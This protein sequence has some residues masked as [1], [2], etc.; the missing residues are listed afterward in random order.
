MKISVLSSGSSGNSTLIQTPE[1]SILIDAGLSAKK[2][3]ERLNDI[4][5]DAGTV[6]GLLV[7]HDH[8]DHISGA[9]II[10]R[11]LKIP[12]YI[13]KENHLSSKDMFEKCDIRYIGGRFSVGNIEIVPFPVSHDGTANYAFN[14]SYAGKKIS[15]I[16]DIGVVTGMVKYNVLE[17]DL[18]VLESNHDRE[19]LKNG[20][21]PWY[22]KQRV[23]GNTGHLS[24]KSACDFI[25][26]TGNIRLRNLILAHLSKENNDPALAFDEMYRIKEENNLSF[27]LWVAKQDEALEL[28]EV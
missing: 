20:P 19:M 26:E 14:I 23:S 12:V 10:A 28:I 21:Y 17:S 7:T 6:N 5:A 1:G 24:N 25:S 8:I 16:T 22:L 11:K 27:R 4:G 3:M 18:I 15:H 9:G 2:L 13:H